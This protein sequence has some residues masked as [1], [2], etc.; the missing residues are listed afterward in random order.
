LRHRRSVGHRLHPTSPANNA[1]AA[2]ACTV[3]TTASRSLLITE[4]VDH[5]EAAARSRADALP[6]H[7]NTERFADVVEAATLARAEVE[8]CA[9]RC[10]WRRSAAWSASSRG[11]RAVPVTAV[12]MWSARAGLRAR[13]GPLAEQDALT[14]TNV[15]IIADIRP[16]CELGWPD[17][18][19]RHLSF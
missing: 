5:E 12:R 11:A 16:L 2:S 18:G 7:G 6:Q 13:I 8:V 15:L 14:C 17:L 3:T 19:A 1:T 4:G 10:W 9:G